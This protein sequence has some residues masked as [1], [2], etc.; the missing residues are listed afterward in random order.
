MEQNLPER[1]A[2]DAHSQLRPAAL[3]AQAFAQLCAFA[4]DS[5]TLARR[6]GWSGDARIFSQWMDDFLI[7]CKREKLLSLSQLPLALLDWLSARDT[8]PN[9]IGSAPILLVGFDRLTPTQRRLLDLAA[10]CRSEELPAASHAPVHRVH[11][12]P[13]SEIAA[14]FAQIRSSVVAHPDSRWLILT[15][16]VAELRGPLER[17]LGDLQRSLP[18]P[19]AAEFTHGVPLASLALVRAAL[20]LLRW[21][22]EPLDETQLL[23][24]LTTGCFTSSEAERETL[25]RCFASLQRGDLARTEWSLEA[26]CAAAG[27]RD[28]AIWCARI[29]AA[30]QSLSVP[31]LATADAWSTRIPDFL[32][33]ALWLDSAPLDSAAYQALQQFHAVLDDCAAIHSI[34]PA[35]IPFSRFLRILHHQL[36]EKSFAIEVAAPQ[37]QIAAPAESAGLTADAIWFLGADSAHWPG[38]GRPNPLLPLALQIQSGMPHASLEIDIDHATTITR[39]LPLAADQLHFS[40]AALQ[41]DGEHFPSAPIVALAGAAI[42]AE[43][44][45]SHATVCEPALSLVED[46][47]P[48]LLAAAVSG[49]AS[50][51][52]HQSQCAFRAFAVHRLHI[53]SPSTAEPGISASLRGRLLHATL[54]RIWGGTESGGLR[55]L[56]DLLACSPLEAFVSRHIASV[57]AQMRPA[58]Q[59]ETISP[60][61]VAIE[62][63]RLTDLLCTWLH[64]EAARHPFTV[65]GCE[66]ANEIEIAGIRLRIRV[67][68]M[69]RIDRIESA[70]EHILILDYKTS[71]H[72]AGV[73]LD[74]RP[75]DAQLPLYTQ[76]Y[77]DEQLEG[78]VFANVVNSEDKLGFR[79]L[80]RSA[81]ASLL[82][83]LP[84]R[85]ALVA[86]PLTTDQLLAWRATLQSLASDFLQGKAEVNPQKYPATCKHCG[87]ESLCRVASILGDASP[88]DPDAD[89]EDA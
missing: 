70:E 81:R 69:D 71:E 86:Q 38:I 15:P 50:V 82:P 27:N 33:A 73:W 11:P 59:S 80:V 64:Y 43:P 16:R 56:N 2:P 89:E 17:A 72:K 65:L 34:L 37:L 84:S 5:L 77:P 23:W 63:Q 19:I 39:R 53:D 83:D 41:P 32:S 62:Q 10:H 52:T 75:D 57:F 55:T 68:R 58:L 51:L 8:P 13:E 74:D 40:F 18:Q 12:D 87:L 1:S 66:V 25:L 49:G 61:L 26:F 24:L 60:S 44:A 88:G 78:L 54:S 67:D 30:V 21:L 31:T 14:C 20:L 29:L 6:L 9:A 36:E 35:P 45:A 22:A 48:P 42:P 47:A 28:A 76:L 46:A 4:P 79:G 3:A 7:L 85:N